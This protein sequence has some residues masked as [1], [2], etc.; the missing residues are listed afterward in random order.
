MAVCPHFLMELHVSPDRG[1]AERALGRV[2]PAAR[3]DD[4]KADGDRATATRVP[5]D[6]PGLG[7]AWDWQAIDRRRVDGATRVLRPG[8]PGV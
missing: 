2:H 5:S 4:D 1:G 7:I 6:E 8:Q 3:R